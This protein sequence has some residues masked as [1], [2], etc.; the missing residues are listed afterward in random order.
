MPDLMKPIQN[1][2]GTSREALVEA[3][4][5]AREACTALM[6]AL[7][8]TGPNGRDYIGHPDAYKRDLEIYRARF[9]AL[10][11]LHNALGDEALEIQTA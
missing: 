8:E 7:G 5:K 9:R 2:N 4:I 3:R 11:E 1:L 6:A 10:D